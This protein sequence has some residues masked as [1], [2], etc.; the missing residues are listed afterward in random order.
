MSNQGAEAPD[1]AALKGGLVINMG[2]TTPEILSNHLTALQAYNKA[3]GPVVLDPVG[4]GATFIRRNAVKALMKGGYF[5]LIKG[6]EGEIQTVLGHSATQQHGVDSGPSSS[7]DVDKARTVKT[8]A[9][10][11]HNV[12]L[13]TG[14]TDYLSD[15]D[16]TYAIHNGHDLLGRITGSGCTL[17]ATLAA[18]LA[19][20][21]EDKLLAALAGILMFEIAAENAAGRDYVRGPGTFVP[22]FLDE[23]YLVYRQTAIGKDDWCNKAKVEL[24]DI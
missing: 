15:G 11:E 8:L 5:D 12:V 9:A 22:V 7:S 17:G 1:L 18:F 20:H 24:M 14:A 6:N 21:K 3:G 13:M 2:T 23:L 19:V 16:R 10:R 4:A